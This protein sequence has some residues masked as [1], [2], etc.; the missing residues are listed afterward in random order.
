MDHREELKKILIDRSILKGDFTLVSGRKSSY[1]I[2]G[3]MTTLHSRG[4][5]LAARLLL[6]LF[7][8]TGYDA[9]AGP[10]IGADPII[11]ALLTLS[12]SEGK[13]KEGLLIRKAGKDHG[14]RKLVEGNITEGM[15]TVIVE[16]VVTTGGSLLKAAREVENE[17][18]IIAGVGIIVDR[19]E[20]GHGNITGA[21]YDFRSI[22]RVSELL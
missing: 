7:A 18:G 2:N 12:A 19:E 20:G 15:R 16:D 8:D 17:G 9:F 22:F 11:G 10:V 14:T 1:Y 21:G 6:E 5:Y 4:L 13:H 3:K